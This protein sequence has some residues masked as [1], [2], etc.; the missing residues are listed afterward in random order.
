MNGIT[1]ILKNTPANIPSWALNSNGQLVLDIY[2][3]MSFQRTKKVEELTIFEEISNEGVFGFALPK[4]EK[5]N[6]VLKQYGNPS[7]YDI[8]LHKKPI[9]VIVFEG[10]KVLRQNT[11]LVLRSNSQ[12]W[13]VQL[14]DD[15]DF[16]K[17]KLN[18]IYPCDIDFGTFQ[19]IDANLQTNWADNAFYEDGDQGVYFPLCHYGNWSTNAVYNDDGNIN[20]TGGADESDFRPW[21]HILALLQKA[22]CKIGWKF[23]SPVLESNWG[24]RLIAYLLTAFDGS[25]GL[26]KFG[27]RAVV[28]SDYTFL[29]GTDP[30]DW[31][32]GVPSWLIYPGQT[33]QAYDTA[34]GGF[35]NSELYTQSIPGV[36]RA[37][38]P[39]DYLFYEGFSGEMTFTIKAK[40]STEQFGD[41]VIFNWAFSIIDSADPD[42]VNAFKG[43]VVS[44]YY[45]A[46]NET[47]S[48]EF[49]TQVIDMQ[50]TWR[51]FVTLQT[52]FID[53]NQGSG[54]GIVD[55]LGGSEFYNTP[56]SLKLRPGMTIN[57]SSYLTCEH[58]V[59]DILKAVLH[60]LGKGAITTDIISRT[61]TVYQKDNTEFWNG[62]KPTPYYLGD[63]I[64]ESLIRCDS[65]KASMRTGIE[66][67]YYRLTFAD[68]DDE[69]SKSLGFSN[70]NPQ[71]AKL[72]DFGENLQY[73]DDIKED[74]N[75]LF[76]PTSNITADDLQHSDVTIGSETINGA[77]EIPALWDNDDNEISQDLGP[78]ILYAHGLNKQ[79]IANDNGSLSFASWSYKGSIINNFPVAFQV[80]GKQYGDDAISLPQN[81]AYGNFDIDLYTLF[82]KQYLTELEK[83]LFIEY[84]AFITPTLFVNETFRK[85]IYVQFNGR[86]FKSK[87]ISITDYE[88]LKTST[89]RIEVMPVVNCEK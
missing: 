68:T 23:E 74:R 11:M 3:D 63:S 58:S 60:I 20:K 59:S 18:S 17:T 37:S 16:W 2:K 76:E 15:S 46:D 64:N 9:K 28:Q 75:P 67:R 62:E 43:V 79:F 80:T 42:P 81:I 72:I 19:T 47:I 85:F 84:D 73:E 36:P 55:I 78:R 52:W 88:G 22:F 65:D 89:A 45:Q 61:V 6:L 38:G 86:K 21:V 25:K 87:L 5:N 24:R 1:I 40:V 4:T 66:K 53:P 10:H 26:D 48:T 56:L 49:T 12:E 70:D 33:L 27:F 34:P 39:V 51:V 8:K 13:E 14:I 31:P 82:W 69:Y 7:I 32:G 77:V 29:T 41:R 35:D 54:N 71:Y 44:P 83:S 50:P 57:I 30:I